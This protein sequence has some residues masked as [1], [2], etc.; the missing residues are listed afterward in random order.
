MTNRGGN[1]NKD[2][3]HKCR[4][5]WRCGREWIKM[6]LN[7]PCTKQAVHIQVIHNYVS[8]TCLLQFAHQCSAIRI[9]Q[10]KHNEF[11]KFSS[12]T[13]LDLYSSQISVVY[14]I[15][16]QNAIWFDLIWVW[17]LCQRLVENDNTHA[18][19]YVFGYIAQ[20][21]WF[22]WVNSDRFRKI[23]WFLNKN[24]SPLLILN[25][26]FWCILI[27]FLFWYCQQF[28]F[29]ISNCE[30]WILKRWKTRLKKKFEK[31]LKKSSKNLFRTFAQKI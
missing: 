12:V 30:R 31:R 27:M 29:C 23:I 24:R 1:R 8:F 17:C 15:I 6:S 16:A 14:Y 28:L 13:R 9:H 11:H 19:C 7:R 10:V 25:D 3:T 5:R 2:Q 26:L 21:G 22:S 18:V 20:F 4:C